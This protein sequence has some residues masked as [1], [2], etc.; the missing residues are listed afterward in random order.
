MFAALAFPK[1]AFSENLPLIPL[2]AS[3]KGISAAESFEI[4]SGTKIY[5]VS[6]EAKNAENAA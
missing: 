1:F 6:D 3:I 5:Y 2:P 4:S